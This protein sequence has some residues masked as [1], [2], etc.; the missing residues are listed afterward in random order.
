MAPQ[1]TAPHAPNPLRGVTGDVAGL[2]Y[3]A[4]VSVAAM[5]V[6]SAHEV[7]ALKVLVATIV[8]LAI[9]YCAH[10]FTRVEADR[11]TNP[12]ASFRDDLEEAE[13]HELT[14]LVGGLPA[15]SVYAASALLGATAAR[16]A[17]I[18][19]WVTVGLLAVFGYLVG[20]RS[21][22]TGW[23]LAVEVLGASLFGIL[24]ALLKAI[25]H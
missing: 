15:I 21:G 17:D 7:N 18:A 10:V 13:K 9:Y 19:V 6:A 20:R 23:R 4:I 5:A 2:L 25:L 8:T 3:G 1:G 12:T 16:A 24:L 11:L 22:A 14:V